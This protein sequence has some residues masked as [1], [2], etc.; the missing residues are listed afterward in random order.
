M[1]RSLDNSRILDEVRGHASV[2]H[3]LTDAVVR[4]KLASTML[5]VG[6]SGVGRKK[7]ALGLL[8]RLVC[9]TLDGCGG[10]GPC[11][12]ISTGQSES[13]MLIEPAKNA[14]K[15]E[16][17]REI[18]DFLSLRGLG[19]ARAIVVDSCHLMNPAT[20][21]ALLKALEEPPE[22]TYFFLLAPSPRHVLPTIRSRA[23]VV[24]FAGLSIEDMQAVSKE[25]RVSPRWMLEAARGSLDRLLELSGDGEAAYGPEAGGRSVRALALDFLAACGEDDAYFLAPEWREFVK[26]R[27]QAVQFARQLLLIA[28]DLSVLQTQPSRPLINEDQRPQVTGLL[29]LWSA[30]LDDLNQRILRLEPALAGFRDPVMTYEEFWISLN[31]H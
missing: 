6:P 25:A 27:E 26:A 18:L 15:V 16:Q 17:A 28:R 8:Q 4:G 5:F 22:S 3:N 13:L 10:C 14:I 24:R 11:R 2:V 21:N 30:R 20:S 9:D 31:R 19:R 7:V 29:A 12:R 23:Q 1:D